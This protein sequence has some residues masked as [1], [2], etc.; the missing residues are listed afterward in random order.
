MRKMAVYL[1]LVEDEDQEFYD[2]DGYDD[3]SGAV[4]RRD[5]PAPLRVTRPDETAVSYTPPRAEWL[6]FRAG[7]QYEH[8]FNLGTNGDSRLQLDIHG[9]F[10]RG[11]IDF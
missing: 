10:L 3:A 2:E 4:A 5:T 7:Y 1:G 6:R 8:W 9:A 11:E